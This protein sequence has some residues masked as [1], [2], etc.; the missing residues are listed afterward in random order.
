VKGFTHSRAHFETENE[1]GNCLSQPVVLL[2]LTEFA[3][4]K[5]KKKSDLESIW[6]TEC[7]RY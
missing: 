5:L 3:R 7:R 2:C 4:K 1:P 6:R